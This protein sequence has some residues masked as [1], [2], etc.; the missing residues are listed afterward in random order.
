MPEMPYVTA[1]FLI[2]LLVKCICI[3]MIINII[4][5]EFTGG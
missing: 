2:L 4:Q 3:D 1:R 5:I